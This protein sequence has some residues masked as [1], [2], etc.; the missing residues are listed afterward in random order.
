MGPFIDDLI[1]SVALTSHMCLKDLYIS[2]RS[3][4]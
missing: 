3:L 1:V 2:L 4:S